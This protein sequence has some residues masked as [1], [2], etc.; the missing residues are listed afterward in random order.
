MGLTPGAYK[1]YFATV[2]GGEVSGFI[3]IED[4]NGN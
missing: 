4:V 3:V 2:C 1:F